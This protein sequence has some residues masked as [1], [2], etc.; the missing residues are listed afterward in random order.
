MD[1]TPY[2][3]KTYFPAP[4]H[5]PVFNDSKEPT[6][7]T[8]NDNELNKYHDDRTYFVRMCRQKI[9]RGELPANFDQWT[10]EQQHEHLMSN[11]DKYFPNIPA[12]LRFILPGIFKEGDCGRSASERPDWLDMDKFRRGQ[13]FAQNYFFG[14]C[15]AQIMSLFFIFNYVDGL[16]TLILSRKSD[17]PYRAFK[18]YLSTVIRVNRW[19]LEDPWDQKTQAHRD[20]QEVR[21]MHLAM[22]R[23]LCNYNYEQIDAK[24]KIL[25]PYCP[26]QKILAQ[27]FKDTCPMAN[28]LQ[29]PF[30]MTRTKSINQGDM[31]CTQFTFMNMIVLYPKKFGVHDV[32]DDDLEAFCHMWRGLGYLLGIEDRYNFCRGSIQEVRE[33]VKD[34]IEYWVK[35][36]LSSVL[37]EWEHMLACLYKGLHYYVTMT[38][39]KIVLLY[40][41]HVLDLNMPR[42]YK[43]LSLMEKA[44]YMSWYFM[45]NYLTK[46][47]VVV[48]VLNAKL[49]SYLNSAVNFGPQKHAELKK[50]SSRLQRVSL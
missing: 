39:Y 40:F 46:L 17:T 22:R 11:V 20:I 43:S 8:L 25:R 23:R 31:S 45:F 5:F 3:E 7:T 44:I 49:R 28:D 34:T 6:I 29:C 32:S 30:M 9:D 15:A 10:V 38:N 27:D 36:Y 16:K 12:S 33:R 2:N 42:L 26:M 19:C 37:P 50:R 4:F 13:K 41:C 1:N 48:A 35:P 24:S 21:S 14:I 18:R 47:P